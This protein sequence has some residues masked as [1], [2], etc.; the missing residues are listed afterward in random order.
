MEV[1]DLTL[2]GLQGLPARFKEENKNILARPGFDPR[3][4]E[5]TVY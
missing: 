4:I 2:G 5:A 1:A 3:T